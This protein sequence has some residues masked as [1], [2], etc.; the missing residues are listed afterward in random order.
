[1]DH[2]ALATLIHDHFDLDSSRPQWNASRARNVGC[3]G[4][5][6]RATE[7]WAEGTSHA[8]A[9][10]EVTMA[11]SQAKR[12]GRVSVRVTNAAVNLSI[13]F[14]LLCDCM[15][16]RIL[17]VI[18][19]DSITVT[20]AADPVDVPWVA[21]GEGEVSTSQSVSV[22]TLDDVDSAQN[23]VRSGR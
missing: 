18:T 4:V 23:F 1:M 19:L 5:E 7:L 3:P 9:G 8:V 17:R 20:S 13:M 14:L 22:Q 16:L 12:R 10:T 15:V 11:Y 2:A 21:T 6:Q